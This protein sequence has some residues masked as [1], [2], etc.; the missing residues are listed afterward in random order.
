MY[1]NFKNQA[2]LYLLIF[3]HKESLYCEEGR[4]WVEHWEPEYILELILMT[5]M[6]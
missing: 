6:L 2:K 3:N 5:P 1:C 4:F